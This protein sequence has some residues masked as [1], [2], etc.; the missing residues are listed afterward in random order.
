MTARVMGIIRRPPVTFRAVVASPRWAG[1][2]VAL[3]L[4]NFGLSAVFLGTEIGKQALVD[5]WERTA[6][7]FGQDVDDE[8]Y[9]QFQDLSR[10]GVAYAALTETLRGPVA[11]FVL[12]GLLYAGFA[13]V[14]RDT[15]ALGQVVAVVVHSTVILTLREVVGAPLNYA[16]ESIASPTTLAQLFPVTNASSPVARFFGLIDLFVIWWLVVLA[17][18]IGVLYARRVWPIAASLAG[19]YAGGAVALAAT[20]AWL[21]GTT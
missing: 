20:M 15:R 17:I 2:L 9:S 12:S 8:R 1:L 7:A 16:R 10:R 11:V 3:F 6:L 13:A 21:G 5:Q 4:V 19:V 14:A 18:G